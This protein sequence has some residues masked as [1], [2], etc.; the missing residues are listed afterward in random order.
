MTALLV[1]ASHPSC[2][3]TAG[4]ASSFCDLQDPRHPDDR[5][6]SARWRQ[7]PSSRWLVKP[8]AALELVEQQLPVANRQPGSS[9]MSNES[10]SSKPRMNHQQ[11]QDSMAALRTCSSGLST[12]MP[13]TLE[14][15]LKGQWLGRNQN[16]AKGDDM[17]QILNNKSKQTAPTQ[18]ATLSATPRTSMEPLEECQFGIGGRKPAKDWDTMN[19]VTEPMSSNRTAGASS[20]GS[21]LRSSLP[22][23][24]AGM[25]PHRRLEVPVASGVL[26]HRLSTF[27]LANT[28]MVA[29]DTQI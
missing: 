8:V 29:P 3:C 7:W 18:S 4:Q 22:E 20:F 14:A 5:R 13:G 11:T 17:P 16:K 23:A 21:P 15:P 24:T 19:E 10:S 26:Q 2:H 9:S 25:Q 6:G 27:S 1:L 12:P 28:R